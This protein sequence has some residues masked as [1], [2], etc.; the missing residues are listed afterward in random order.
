MIEGP[1]IIRGNLKAT[2]AP[3]PVTSCLMAV[4]WNAIGKTRDGA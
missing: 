1:V 4:K 3:I 2:S